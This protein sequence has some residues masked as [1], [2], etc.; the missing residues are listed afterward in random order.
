MPVILEY[1]AIDDWLYIRQSSASLMA[2]LRPAR[3]ESLIATPVS[4]RANAVKNDDPECLAPR[5]EPVAYDALNRP[6]KSG[7]SKP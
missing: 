2:L 6:G 4:S 3:D 7:G 1:E 5:I